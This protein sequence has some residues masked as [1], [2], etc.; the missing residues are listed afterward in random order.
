MSSPN[1]QH[2]DPNDV[3]F[4]GHYDG[5]LDHLGY[6]PVIPT[7]F[8]PLQVTYEFPF[9]RQTVHAREFRNV[10]LN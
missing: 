8:V 3:P 9:D 6:T 5:V 2:N 4:S 10:P 7:E 1:G